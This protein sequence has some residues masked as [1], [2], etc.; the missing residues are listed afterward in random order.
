VRRF[1]LAIAKRILPARFIQW[2]RRRRALRRYLKD[3]A[4]EVYDRGARVDA[5][6]LEGRL[7]ARRDGFY[8]RL[9]HDVIERSDLILQELDRRIEGLTARHGNEIHALRDDLQGLR[10]DLAAL[11]EEVRGLGRPVEGSLRV[12]RPATAVRTTD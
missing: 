4:Y 7:M 1:L 9:V 11:R 10:D 8:D 6:E 12:P 2:Y 5:A 3:L